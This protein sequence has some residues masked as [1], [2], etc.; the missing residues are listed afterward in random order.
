MESW[1]V[2]NCH[3]RLDYEVGNEENFILEEFEILYNY[4]H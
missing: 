1:A 4:V 2:H 3:F